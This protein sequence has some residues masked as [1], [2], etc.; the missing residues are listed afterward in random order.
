MVSFFFSVEVS[1]LPSVV[2]SLAF[3][4]SPPL[5]FP[6]LSFAVSITL[7]VIFTLFFKFKAL[8]ISFLAVIVSFKLTL[9]PA[10]ILSIVRDL[11][12]APALYEVLESLEVSE[13]LGVLSLL[14]PLSPSTETNICSPVSVVT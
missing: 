3:P 10:W 2:P 4:P 5:A 1:S 14:L 11:A 8:L 13:V 9:L 7:A 6:L 12:K